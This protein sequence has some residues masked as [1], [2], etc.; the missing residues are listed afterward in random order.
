LAVEYNMSQR[1][2]MIGKTRS[3]KTRFAIVIAGMYAQHLWPPWEIWWIDTKGD[4]D[5][6]NA[7]RQFG[8]RN[9]ANMQDMRSP[10]AIPG[11]FYFHIEPVDYGDPESVINQAQSVFAY[12]MQ[13]GNNERM[14]FNNVLVVVDEYV[15][16]VPSSRSPGAALKDILQRGGGMK[17]GLIGLTQEPVY[18]PRQLVSQA[19]HIF[20]FNLTYEYDIEWVRR[21]YR[22]YEPPLARGDGYGFYH[23]FVDGLQQE[24]TYY[25][26]QFEWFE[27]VDIEIPL[28]LVVPA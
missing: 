22:G 18:V 6:L 16:V 27:N 7:L 20:L 11:A 1:Y 15:A 2:A 8:F 21:I 26:N 17:T 5:D 19:T 25:R 23:I 12:A 3:G 4:L 13:R 10:G 14:A 24:V 28:A 9:G